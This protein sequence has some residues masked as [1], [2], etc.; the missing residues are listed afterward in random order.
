MQALKVA[1]RI[2]QPGELH[3]SALPLRVGEARR[4]DCRDRK[5]DGPHPADEEQP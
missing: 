1:T 3:L 4:S 5:C 2:E